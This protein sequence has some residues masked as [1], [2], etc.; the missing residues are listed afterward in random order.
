MRCVRRGGQ[1][2]ARLSVAGAAPSA[3]RAKSLRKR[4]KRFV[5][6]KKPEPPT[7][8]FFFASWR[9]RVGAE[10]PSLTPVQVNIHVGF[11]GR[12]ERVGRD[13]A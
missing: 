11:F 2:G 3:A 1:W 6:K 5:V 12:R 13:G 10:R 7:R 9:P 8:V 4:R